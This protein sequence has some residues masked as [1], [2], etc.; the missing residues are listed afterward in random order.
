MKEP[1][2][3]KKKSLTRKDSYV[4]ETQMEG[5][6]PETRSFASA[7]R[8]LR[9]SRGYSLQR[10]SDIANVSKSMISKLEREEVQPSLDI[11]IRLADSL[12]THLSAM[13]RED[14]TTSAIKI[15]RNDQSVITDPEGGWERRL[16]SPSFKAANIEILRGT[17]A[18]GAKT[19]DPIMHPRNAEEYIVLLQGELHVTVGEQST[20]LEPGDSLYFEGDQ[21][22]ALE[23]VSDE[24]AD[25]IVVI[26]YQPQTSLRLQRD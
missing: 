10:L 18:P 25:L 5:F 2:T 11:A 15:P 23:C 3:P 7:L 4:A 17:L 6:S 12:Q 9:T 1:S 20:N 8:E 14:T 22:H 19:G 26:R 21:S 13:I 16:L 24:P